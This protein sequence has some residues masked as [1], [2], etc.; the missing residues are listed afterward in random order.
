[1][2]LSLVLMCFCLLLFF[3]CSL[4][5]GPRP[6]VGHGAHQSHSHT[7]VCLA[8]EKQVSAKLV[9]LTGPRGDVSKHEIELNIEDEPF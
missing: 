7:S 9:H 5:R 6:C 8:L 2:I 4:G 3:R 1:M